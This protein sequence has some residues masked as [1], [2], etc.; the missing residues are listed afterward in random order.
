[1]P[2][3]HRHRNRHRW[4]RV[5]DRGGDPNGEDHSCT[6]DHAGQQFGVRGRQTE[7]RRGFLARL[8]RRRPRSRH[9]AAGDRS[10]EGDAPPERDEPTA[11]GAARSEPGDRN[12]A[13]ATDGPPPDLVVRALGATEVWSRGVPIERWASLRGLAILRY[14]VLHRS[15]PVHREVLMDLL[16]PH[17]ASQAARNNLN[18]A[19]Y[20]LRR[21]LGAGGDGPYITYHD[22]C[23]QLAPQLDTWVDVDGF[24]CARMTGR[25][26]LAA[27]DVDRAR[28]CLVT[29]RDL[30]R[31]P[32]FAD[33]ASD[34]YLAER[35]VLEERYTSVLEDLAEI[36]LRNG[37]SANCVDLCHDLLRVDPCRET[38]H[39][40]LMNA[41]GELHQYHLVARQYGEC[42]RTLQEQLDVAPDSETTG[43][44]MRHLRNRT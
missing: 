20:G 36:D 7:D 33:D 11:D 40:L 1:M 23:Y 38:T 5:R 26:H 10:P 41:Y 16:W 24:N 15:V 43:V 21:S 30:Y 42:V 8:L 18:V 39:R 4:D 22:G 14:L 37:D 9:A 35:R 34:W 25:E 27:G 32:L 2:S 12:E 3:G 31:G 6:V 28:S 13:P 19:I 17:S 44:F 29:A